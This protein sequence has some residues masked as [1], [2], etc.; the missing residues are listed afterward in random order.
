MATRM[1]T[2][3]LALAL[4]W[5]LPHVTTAADA[6]DVTTLVAKMKAALEPPK[7]S[8]RQ[9]KLSISGEDG[10]TTQWSLAQARKTV[11]GQGRMLNVVLAPADDRGIASLVIDGKPPVTALYVPAVRRV[12]TLV[13][14]GGYEPVLGS[15]FTYADLGFV[16]LNDK[17]AYV[18]AEKKNGKDAW[19]VEQVID[20]PWYYSKIVSWIDQAN[21]LP[22]ERDYYDPAGQLWKVETFENVATID[23]QPVA[24]RVKM[25]DKT[26]GGTS[27]V[28]VSNLRFGVDLTDGLFRKEGLSAAPSSPVW[29]GLK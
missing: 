26:T 4:S 2:V 9:M 27:V 21:M 23:G 7:S 16:R 12:R 1:R 17:Y 15:D 11:D 28:D 19:K 5:S 13:P 6:P 3:L 29:A 22:I 10:G 18:G 25:Q 8:L 20:N 24:L 14:L